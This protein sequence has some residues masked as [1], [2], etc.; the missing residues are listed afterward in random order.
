MKKIILFL[1]IFLLTFNPTEGFIFAQQTGPH[2]VIGDV[3]PFTTCEEGGYPQ[4]TSFTLSKEVVAVDETFKI[5]TTVT[6]LEDDVNGIPLEIRW[7]W[8]VGNG[9]NYD[10]PWTTET[11]T[12]HSYSKS[13]NY[14]ITLQVRDS[15][16]QTNS[17]QREV[18]VVEYPSGIVSAKT[19]DFS[20]TLSQPNPQA[21]YKSE[22]SIY[23]TA[24]AKVN[25]IPFYSD[26]VLETNYIQY[27][28]S[29]MSLPI[30]INASDYGINLVLPSLNQ[31]ELERQEIITVQTG[32]GNESPKGKY[33][34]NFRLKALKY[35]EEEKEERFS[36]EIFFYIDKSFLGKFEILNLVATSCTAISIVWEK[37]EEAQG[38]Q[39]YRKKEGD[40]DYQKIVEIPGNDPAYCPL[41]I[42]NCSFTD[43]KGIEENTIY[44]YYIQAYSGMEKMNNKAESFSEKA[45]FYPC[46]G[47]EQICP[48]KITAPFCS[49]EWDEPRGGGAI[50]KCGRIELRWPFK[51]EV[52]KYHLKRGTKQY[53]QE[54]TDAYSF[55]PD[56]EIWSSTRGGMRTKL[57]EGD[58]CNFEDR[59]IIPRVNYFYHFTVESK[60]GESAPSDTIGPFSSFCFKG[61]RWK[62]K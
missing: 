37:A 59:N 34:L 24:T 53:T 49:P 32:V 15:C 31:Q 19:F 8:D 40:I 17:A 50:E 57:C 52:D 4:I 21:G 1:S 54:H 20:L 42:N 18:R 11:A 29:V 6:D 44:L 12:S 41:E 27:Q 2:S 39:I 26:F 61:P 28:A 16:G 10:T 14:Q 35:Y 46:E 55:E 23:L 13:G 5:Q 3:W 62:E 9:L 7:D 45:L 22:D 56:D 48:W 47:G 43:T 38:Y 51:P 25:Q 33:I 60:G 36:E 30:T 58:W